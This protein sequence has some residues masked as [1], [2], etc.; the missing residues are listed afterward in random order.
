MTALTRGIGRQL[1]LGVAKETTRGTAKTAATYWLPLDDW[2]VEEKYKNVTLGQTYAVLEAG[3]GQ[4]RH[5][6][7]SEG[8]LKIPITDQSVPLIFLSLFGTDTVST[9]GS[10]AAVYNHLI[11]VG[12]TIQHQSLTFFKHDP[13]TGQDYSFAN[14]VVHK[15]EIDYAL[16]KLCEMT[17]SIKGQSGVK[18]SNY[19]PSQSIENVFVP[20]YLTFKSAANIAGLGAATAIKLKSAKITIDAGEMDDDVMGQVA[21]RDFLNGEFKS[22]GSL[23]AIFQNE[24]DFKANAI[25]NTAQA[26]QFD[27]VNTD[28]TIGSSSNPE[29]KIVLAQV[30]FT[31]FS[32]PVKIKDVYYQTVKFEAVYNVANTQMAQ[33]TCVNTVASY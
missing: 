1:S 25:A 3:V 13:I 26:L 31:E 22:S 17:V 4:I 28:V 16:A 7:W 6:Q 15:V 11:T 8:S 2:S 30:Y 5:K 20:Q 9:H 23:E 21:P 33:V 10:E 29:T 14:G 24:T 19:S 27:L 32:A 18:Q 12:Q